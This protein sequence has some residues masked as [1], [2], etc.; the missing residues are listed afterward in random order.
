MSENS[1]M[2]ALKAIDDLHGK[3]DRLKKALTGEEIAQILR[4]IG[5][6]H[7]KT[8]LRIFD[9]MSLSR[10]PE[11]ELQMGLTHLQGALTAYGGAGIDEFKRYLQRRLTPDKVVNDYRQACL[12]ALLIAVC[13]RKQGDPKL[14]AKYAK[15]AEDFFD[16][17]LEAT[18]YYLSFAM[19]LWGSTANTNFTTND[20]DMVRL[21]R[22]FDFLRQLLATLQDKAP[23]FFTRN[24]SFKVVR[25]QELGRLSDMP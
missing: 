1:M 13:Y 5:D 6:N 7:F 3:I 22:E 14:V 25:V 21:K 19:R 23:P 16:L 9:D 24:Y 2:E 17:Y 12:C 10:D 20:P 18:E 15:Y 11:R 8:A 4:T